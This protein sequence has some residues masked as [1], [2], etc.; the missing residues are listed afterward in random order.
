MKLLIDIGNTSSKLAVTDGDRFVH[1]ERLAEPWPDALHRLHTAYNIERIAV[2]CVGRAGGALRHALDATPAAFAPHVWLD[3]ATPC[4]ISGVPQGY[5]ADRLAA[6]IGAY[7]GQ[8]ALLVIDAGT[9][10]TYDLIVDG[11][12]AGGVISPGVQLRLN[13]MHDYTAALPLVRADFRAAAAEAGNE[14]FDAPAEEDSPASACPLLAT[15]THGCMLSAALHGARFEAEGYIRA[16]LATYPH[17]CVV[18]TGGTPLH[19]SQDLPH[20][21]DPLLVLRG[22]NTL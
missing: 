19:I 16:L 4:A 14:G 18:T 7:T 5:G 22:L 15:N 10:I 2:S 3:Y 17:L 21:Y 13:A 8:H 20:V 9:C 11:R 6:D 12:L 1:T